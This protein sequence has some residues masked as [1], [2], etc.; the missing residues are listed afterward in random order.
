MALPRD[1]KSKANNTW[2]HIITQKATFA[3]PINYL[4][5]KRRGKIRQWC[6]RMAIGIMLA[7]WWLRSKRFRRRGTPMASTVSYT[8][9][10]L[11]SAGAGGGI[12]TRS[13]LEPAP[14][15]VLLGT[16]G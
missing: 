9:A 15:A 10:C 1:F 4:D 11:P 16:R 12:E 13:G 3:L 7:A 6:Y 8:P 2:V 14:T 5:K